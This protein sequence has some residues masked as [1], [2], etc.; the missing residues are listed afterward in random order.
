MHFREVSFKENMPKHRKNINRFG[1]LK[2]NQR[3]EKTKK[4]QTINPIISG[5]VGVLLDQKYNDV[6][7]GWAE[8]KDETPRGRTK[9]KQIES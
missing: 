5:W 1:I 3:L 8:E 4:K 7:C 6:K 9:R 2:P